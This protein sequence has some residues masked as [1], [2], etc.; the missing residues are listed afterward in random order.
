MDQTPSPLSALTAQAVLAQSRQLRE[1]V[2]SDVELSSFTT[3][4][5]HAFDHDQDLA[6]VS[7]PTHYTPR[8][9][10]PPRCLTKSELQEK[11]DRQAR[12]THF[13]KH[14]TP[15]DHLRFLHADLN[16]DDSRMRFFG[17]RRLSDQADRLESH[18]RNAV[19]SK[20][21]VNDGLDHIDEL[22]GE[23]QVYATQAD[24]IWGQRGDKNRHRCSRRYLKSISTLFV[25]VDVYAPES[26]Y[27]HLEKQEV[28]EL[29]F[30]RLE[31]HH[32]PRPVVIDSG[33]GVY[34]Y[35]AFG[36]RLSLR[37]KANFELWQRVQVKLIHLLSD[38]GADIKVKD[39]TR[40]LRLVGTKNSK[41][42][43]RVSVVYDDGQYHSLKSL[44]K[45]TSRLETPQNWMAKTRIAGSA[46]KSSV[47]SLKNDL[48]KPLTIAK[49]TKPIT[50]G[51]P[52][53]SRAPK[54]LKTSQKDMRN[55]WSAHSHD[56]SVFALFIDSLRVEFEK[57]NITSKHSLALR[58][59]RMFMD[60]V[61]LVQKRG[62]VRSGYRNDFTFWS[63]SLLY[64]ARLVKL[65]NISQVCAQLSVICQDKFN[66]FE[67]GALSSLIARIKE[68][69]A[70]RTEASKHNQAQSSDLQGGLQGRARKVA[71]KNWMSAI[72]SENSFRGYGRRVY[73]P[74]VRF[75]VES[76]RITP[77]EQMALDCLTDEIEK[78]R[79]R[80]LYNASH[81]IGVRNTQIATMVESGVR[82]AVVKDVFN[83]SLATVYRALKQV[84]EQREQQVEPMDNHVSFDGAFYRYRSMN[85]AISKS[86]NRT[87][88]S[89]SRANEPCFAS[90]SHFLSASNEGGRHTD[91]KILIGEIDMNMRNDSKK[92]RKKEK[93]AT[94]TPHSKPLSPQDQ[95]LSPVLHLSP[96][97]PAYAY[98]S[99]TLNP[100]QFSTTPPKLATSKTLSQLGTGALT[101]HTHLPAQLVER[102]RALRSRV[103]QQSTPPP[104]AVKLSHEA[105]FKKHMYSQL[106]PPP[107]PSAD[108]S[109][110]SAQH[111]LQVE[112]TRDNQAMTERSRID[113]LLDQIA[114][115]RSRLEAVG[116]SSQDLSFAKQ[117]TLTA[118]PLYDNAVATVTDS[119][120]LELTEV[121][122]LYLGVLRYEL[123]ILDAAI[124]THH[125]VD[126]QDFDVLKRVDDTSE[127]FN[128]VQILRD[129]VRSY[130]FSE[131]LR[132]MGQR[133]DDALAVFAQSL[134]VSDLSLSSISLIDSAAKEVQ[135]SLRKELEVLN[136][137]ISV[138]T[139]LARREA[140]MD[141][142]EAL[143]ELINRVISDQ[144]VVRNLDLDILIKDIS[145]QVVGLVDVSAKSTK[146]KHLF[147]S[148]ASISN[149]C[150]FINA[151]NHEHDLT[152]QV[153]DQQ[154]KLIGAA[155][156]Y[157][158]SL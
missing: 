23:A 34:L 20:L 146:A 17:L 100:N 112:R 104:S 119:L 46:A 1:S 155:T 24:F 45:I 80:S 63:I 78:K 143:I 64:N 44:G 37:R 127:L 85:K 79:R 87:K 39:L 129:Q 106:P 88:S 33:R 60:L 77:T 10:T 153:L 144:N 136:L 109:R 148:V 135:R 58:Y 103:Y 90:D 43:T 51:S 18:L 42:S 101:L 99:K 57:K 8:K 75:L 6:V 30:D 97:S 22:V 96:L 113:L 139:R 73:T 102:A 54:L 50:K 21:V 11:A 15:R 86:N 59:Y 137:R 130:E 83:V 116:A 149:M 68:D 48:P 65:E 35:W 72:H 152:Q 140:D 19:A 32:I 122:K 156:L 92:E 55:T 120:R 82:P 108:M 126:S 16:F 61:S 38:F 13:P 117:Q 158:F 2:S 91:T 36:E 66:T 5:L 157:R 3:D 67:S 7:S 147:L 70:D 110:V 150:L 128:Q 93:N 111:A 142:L 84:R 12:Q 123:S 114:S 49:Q 134:Q 14:P 124:M 107:A 154:N 28:V 56:L 27:H 76:F 26:Q 132:Q 121:T 53:L 25:D 125:L 131:L 29:I 81:Q 138:D 62:G 105:R 74:S 89:T 95:P 98:G 115:K 133:S 69:Q 141:A 9:R 41:S 47:L 118:T 52:F 31:A 151:L 71:V 145:E 4:G 40:V 94:I